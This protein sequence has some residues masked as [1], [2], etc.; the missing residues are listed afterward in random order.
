MKY[1]YENY[2]DARED[3]AG[4]LVGLDIHPTPEFNF[5]FDVVDALGSKKPDRRAMLWVG[6]DGAERTFTF[7]DMK[8]LSSQTANYLHSLGIGRG[9]VVMLVLRRHYQFWYTLMALHKL[10]AVA[11]PVT[12]QLKAKDFA[13]RFK[14]AGVKAVVCTARGEAAAMVEAALHQCPTVRVKCLCGGTRPGWNNFDPGV[15]R[16]SHVFFRPWGETPSIATTRH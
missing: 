1:I 5:A 3:D 10:G 11:L 7:G 15:G 8:R 4:R 6:A 2:I 9:D 12:D 13:Y 16:S 14:A